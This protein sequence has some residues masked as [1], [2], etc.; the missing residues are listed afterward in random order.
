MLE[1]EEVHVSSW[2]QEQTDQSQDSMP[3]Q[4]FWIAT[5]D[6]FISM[7]SPSC[8][9]VSWSSL[10]ELAIIVAPCCPSNVG[11]SSWLWKPRWDPPS[12]CHWGCSLPTMVHQQAGLQG[13]WSLTSLW[14]EHPSRSPAGACRWHRRETFLGQVEN[15]SDS[16]WEKKWGNLDKSTGPSRRVPAEQA[17]IWQSS[18]CWPK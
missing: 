6:P 5:R 7:S 17:C 10:R 8:S 14:I 15:L 12:S 16:A 13:S 1:V 2:H 9:S 4:R 3:V 11:P 18:H